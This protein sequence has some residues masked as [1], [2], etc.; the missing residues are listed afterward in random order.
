M[1]PP[2]SPRV[3]MVGRSSRVSSFRQVP[4]RSETELSREHV[5][6]TKPDPV[7]RSLPPVVARHDEGKLAHDVRRV[8]AQKA[9]LFQGLEDEG[10]VSLLQVAHASVDELRAPARGPS[11]EVAGLEERGAVSAGGGIES[12]A[13]AA[14]A[15]ADDENVPA[16]RLGLETRDHRLAIHGSR[17]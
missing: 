10:H 7:E 1:T 9:P 12:A 13:E 17:I 14:R 5:V 8:S 2:R 11:S 3:S 4:R 15:A 16:P 6:E